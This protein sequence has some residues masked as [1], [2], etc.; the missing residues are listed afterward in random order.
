MFIYNKM[1]ILDASSVSWLIAIYVL[2]LSAV[3]FYIIYLGASTQFVNDYKWMEQKNLKNTT[4]IVLIRNMRNTPYNFA[5][6][7]VIF[8]FLIVTT[9]IFNKY[10]INIRG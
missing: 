1:A 6:A 10:K 3:S 9:L 7:T 2:I 8:N 4:D 5:I